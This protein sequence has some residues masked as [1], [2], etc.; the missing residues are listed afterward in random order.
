MIEKSTTYDIACENNTPYE[1]KFGKKCCFSPLNKDTTEVSRNF[2]AWVI[3]FIYSVIHVKDF[4]MFNVLVYAANEVFDFVNT[5]I[6]SNLSTNSILRVYKVV[7]IWYGNHIK[8][9]SIVKSLGFL[10][11]HIQ[12]KSLVY[13][14]TG[15]PRMKDL[16]DKSTARKFIIRKL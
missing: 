12:S 14:S 4:S 3:I 1:T 8:M 2:F 10:T 5:A 7:S 11:W 9:F 16:W 13:V 15:F 6:S